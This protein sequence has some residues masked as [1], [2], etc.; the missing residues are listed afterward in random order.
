M[1]AVDVSGMMCEVR[2]HGKQEVYVFMVVL[3]IF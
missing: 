1:N 3:T 2:E